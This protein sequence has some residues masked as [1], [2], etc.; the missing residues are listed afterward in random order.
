MDLID[1]ILRAIPL[2]PAWWSSHVD[3]LIKATPLFGGAV[4]PLAIL[5]SSFIL[6]MMMEEMDNDH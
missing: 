2:V 5:L 3:I 4:F 6:F 1:I